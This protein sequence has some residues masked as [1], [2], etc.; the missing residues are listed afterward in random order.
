MNNSHTILV[1]DDDPAMINLIIYHF[2]QLENKYEFLQ[3]RDGESGYRVAMETQPDLIILDWEMPGLSG[4]DMLHLLK[5]D[6]K[7]A[8]IPVIMVTGVMTTIENLLTAFDAGAIDYIQK[9]VNQSELIARARSMLMLS[10]SYK[11]IIDIKK[12]ELLSSATNLMQYNEFNINL[13][14]DIKEI[15]VHYGTKNKQL[16][17]ALHEI[18]NKINLQTRND[19]WGKFEDYY[20]QVDPQFFTKLT[21]KFP[22]LTA[23]EIKLCALLRL[24]LD[25]KEIASVT[26]QDPNSIRVARTRLRKKLNLNQGENLTTFLLSIH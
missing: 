4:I 8:T 19:A 18:I 20:R 17:A 2:E 25:T 10:D 22:E 13:L 23:G 15:S 1:V 14:K 7:T 24:N 21:E 5:K 11:K 9:P 26:F 3:A 12:R 6:I 16:D